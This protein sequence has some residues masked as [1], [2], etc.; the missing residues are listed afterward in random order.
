MEIS[1]VNQKKF[2]S[3]FK[4]FP[5]FRMNSFTIVDSSLCKLAAR[6]TEP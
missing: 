2:T 5:R 4:I 6:S 3:A 1:H